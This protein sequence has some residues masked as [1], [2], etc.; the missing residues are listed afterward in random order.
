MTHE[1]V[2]GCRCCARWFCNRTPDLHEA[3][4]RR[5]T[6]SL[7]SVFEHIVA[8]RP[9]CRSQLTP[10]HRLLK[11]ELETTTGTRIEERRQRC[12]RVAGLE[13]VHRLFRLLAGLLPER[14]QGQ[15]GVTC[16][17]CLLPS[18]SI[19][20]TAVIENQ[21]ICGSASFIQYVL[22]WRSLHKRVSRLCR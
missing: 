18:S 13:A 11:P 16:F 17:F 12:S 9:P 1:A 20:V 3:K 8:H 14:G 10:A 21:I 6:A 4:L 22:S 15:R 7:M 2:S 5:C 19:Q